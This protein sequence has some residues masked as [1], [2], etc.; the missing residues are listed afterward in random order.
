MI[1]FVLL[2]LCLVAGLYLLYRWY[3]RAHP[4]EILKG[5]KWASIILGGILLVWVVLS[6]AK[7]LAAFALPLLLPLI[8]RLIA[9]FR[10]IKA[11]NGPTPGKTTEV[12]T[13]FLRMTLDHDSGRMEGTVI[14]GAFRGRRLSELDD[15]EIGELLRECRA[16]DE[17]S[18]KL[19]E[20]Y[21]SRER[22]TADTGEE[23]ASRHEEQQ[24]QRRARGRPGGMSTAEAY[25]I[26][27]L[28]P[29]ATREDILA[30]HRRLM[31]QVH[32]DH[33]GSNY[34]AAKINQAKDV[35]L[36]GLGRG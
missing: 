19:L 26:L 35:L 4:R 36:A 27:D 20:S 24:D 32:P 12:E 28:E 16:E 31:L 2:G 25:Q 30:A 29:G 10:R 22:S 21:I 7:A 15:A 23:Y 14:Q 17:D 8:P 33:G 9:V 13:V 11:A 5:L 3:T 6:G 34:L 18:A 1:R